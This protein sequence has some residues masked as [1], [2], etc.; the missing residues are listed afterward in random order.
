MRVVRR[1]LIGMI[2]AILGVAGAVVAY[3]AGAKPGSR[4]DQQKHAKALEKCKT[5][6]SESKRKKC[7]KTAKAKYKSKTTTG[8]QK[9]AGTGTGTSTGTGTTGTGTG[10]ATGTRAA[11]GRGAGAATGTG[12]GTGTGTETGTLIVHVYQEGGAFVLGCTGPP[13]CPLEGYPVYVGRIGPGGEILSQIETSD[14][15]I[16]VAAGQ[17]DVG[18]FKGREGER[19]RV[20]PGQ[21]VEV[22]LVLAV[23]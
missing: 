8:G 1:A 14:D 9:G 22:N 12:A 17:Y 11:T 18:L 4:H 6:K 23:P 5:D 7:E 2:V 10:A 3:P 16:T 13:H 19:T 21:T 15:T 20:G